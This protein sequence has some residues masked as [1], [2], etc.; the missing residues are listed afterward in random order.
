MTWPHHTKMEGGEDMFQFGNGN[1]MGSSAASITDAAGRQWTGLGNGA[2]KMQPV[3][4]RVPG[5]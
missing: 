5:L 4:F 1:S 2:V 3:V